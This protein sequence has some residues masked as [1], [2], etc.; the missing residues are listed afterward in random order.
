MISNAAGVAWMMPTSTVFPN[1]FLLV[2]NAANAEGWEHLSARRAV[3]APWSWPIYLGAIHV[4]LPGPQA[5][6]SEASSDPAPA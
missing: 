4:D 2:V 5:R 3:F 1:E 6:A